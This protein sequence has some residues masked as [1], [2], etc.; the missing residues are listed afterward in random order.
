MIDQ[1]IF[2]G[3]MMNFYDFLLKE[4]AFYSGVNLWVFIILFFVLFVYGVLFVKEGR[5]LLHMSV[6]AVMFCVG[7][8][9]AYHRDVYNM[10]Q[11]VVLS[12]KELINKIEF[13]LTEYN[14]QWEARDEIALLLHL[15]ENPYESLSKQLIT[16]CQMEQHESNAFLECGQKAL[17]R[18]L[19]NEVSKKI[20]S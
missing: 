1:T 14:R 17:Y 9:Y 7:L 4:L 3:L 6:F 19:K 18:H 8:S 13:D 5:V 15:K 12:E 16:S 10:M 20:L 2:G 11:S